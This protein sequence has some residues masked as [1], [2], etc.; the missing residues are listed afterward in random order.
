M[1]DAQSGVYENRENIELRFLRKR[2]E[3]K[4]R[5]IIFSKALD[6][7]I[8][9]EREAVGYSVINPAQ[10]LIYKVPHVMIRYR[11]YYDAKA[12]KSIYPR[13]HLFWIEKANSW[14]S[15]DSVSSAE[16][17]KYAEDLIYSGAYIPNNFM[18]KALLESFLISE[19]EIS[20]EEVLH[21][22]DAELVKR[23]KKTYS[24]NIH[25]RKE[26]DWEAI[27]ASFR[28]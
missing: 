3:K 12:G 25:K 10:K 24:P 19:D 20:L 23:K 2:G 4:S 6:I 21:T 9:E 27:N 5:V 16:L 18:K 7:P 13:T 8:A 28:R 11:E 14:I 22:N 17:I 15:V 1:K 26:P